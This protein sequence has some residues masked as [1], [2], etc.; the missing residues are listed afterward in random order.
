MKPNWADIDRCGVW[1]VLGVTECNYCPSNEKCWV[2]EIDLERIPTPEKLGK[3][4][5]LEENS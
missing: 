2:P 4:V 3:G 5:K 1:K